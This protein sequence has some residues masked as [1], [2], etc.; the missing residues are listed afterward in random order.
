MEA[1]ISFTNDIIPILRV[2]DVQ[3]LKEFYVDFLGFNVDWQHQI[4]ENSPLYMQVSQQNCILHL[5]EHHGDASPGSTIRIKVQQIL[6]LHQNLLAKNYKYARPG[7]EETPW[8]TTE[9]TVHDPF[10]NKLIFYEGN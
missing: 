6:T 10:G 9:I 1:G 8:G 2:F 5:S 7:L 4:E 3:K